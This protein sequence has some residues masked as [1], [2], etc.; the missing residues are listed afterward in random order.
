MGLEVYE[1][2]VYRFM[3]YEF[4]VYR[5]IALFYKLINS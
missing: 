5:F 1:F 2:M 3:V 4:M